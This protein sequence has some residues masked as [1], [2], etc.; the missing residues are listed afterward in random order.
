MS[1]ALDQFY[2]ILYHRSHPHTY[3]PT[4][5]SDTINPPK[6]PDS[7]HPQY[8]TSNAQLRYDAPP[9][10]PRPPKI[11]NPRNSKRQF[12]RFR[13]FP[14]PIRKKIDGKSDNA[15]MRVA[16]QPLRKRLRLL[17]K[18]K[19]VHM[20]AETFNIVASRKFEALCNL[21]GIAH[22]HQPRCMV[23]AHLHT[24]PLRHPKIELPPDASAAWNLLKKKQLVVGHISKQ[25][26]RLL[27]HRHIDSLATS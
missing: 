7:S 19:E 3:I 6:C 15:R 5:T 27:F 13:I 24:A 17:Q 4:S 1:E 2:T 16:R 10:I 21:I 23:N 9:F 22:E 11:I 8:P 14:N 18:I 26:F 25:R 20:V 12:R